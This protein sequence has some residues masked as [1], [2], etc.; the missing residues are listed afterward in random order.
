METTLDQARQDVQNAV[1]K[2][3]D[4]AE[5]AEPKNFFEFEKNLWSLVLGI[6]RALVVV[7][8]VVRSQRP[9]N[10]KYGHNDKSFELC[11]RFTNE[12]GTLFGKVTWT[13]PAGRR[14]GRQRGV[15]DLPV[16]RELG[17]CGGFSLSVVARLSK[18]SA[19]M[20]F[21]SALK[22]FKDVHEWAPASRTLLRM[23]DAIGALARPFLEGAKAP[24][25]DG[26]FLVAMVDAGGAPTVSSLE[27]KRRRRPHRD[28]DATG[29]STRKR[30]RKQ[31]PKVRR[32]KGKKS[33]NA[34]MAVVGVLFSFRITPYGLEG[35][36]NKQMVATFESHEAL[37]A[38][39]HGE[40]VKRGYGSKQMVFIADGCQHIWR[41]QQK[42]FPD[43][44]AC[45]DWYHIIE[46]IWQAGECLYPENSQQLRQWVKQQSMRLRRGYVDL[47]IRTIGQAHDNTSKTGPGNK[48]KRKRLR[49]IYE[50][51]DKNRSRLRYAELRNKDLDIGSGAVEG[52]VR[53]L[54]RLRLDGPG[55]RWGRGRSELVLHLRCILLNGQWEHFAE[56]LASQPQ[57]KLPARAAPVEPHDAKRKAA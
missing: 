45:I 7:F 24:E 3:T 51:L 35:P 28:V 14:D 16:D 17:L 30:R 39:L 55:M 49:A 33:K 38:W 52:A 50:H 29:R 56:H 13:R 9:R 18:L 27:L 46:K 32:S 43:A 48:G 54:I 22:N 47:V 37:F 44:L 21:A 20:V 8:L 11:E 15:M 41:L 25:G 23:T 19:Q 12:L 42:Y 2:A 53:S 6:G 5:S 57:I 40:A 36:I 1:K 26:E 34:K 10:V 4:W 31:Y